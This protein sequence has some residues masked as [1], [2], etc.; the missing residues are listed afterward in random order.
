MSW[1]SSLLE[2]GGTL[3]RIMSQ[4]L[5]ENPTIL[6]A[7]PQNWKPQKPSDLDVGGLGVQSKAAFEA[8]DHIVTSHMNSIGSPCILVEDLSARTSDPCGDQGLPWV[9]L[10]QDTHEEIYWVADSRVW[11]VDTDWILGAAIDRKPITVFS[12]WAAEPPDACDYVAPGLLEDV[13]RRATSLAA[14]A[15]DGESYIV[16]MFEQ[17]REEP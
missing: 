5:G 3:S 4:R 15:F 12:T 17:P 11:P 2:N 8:L 10:R 1:M 14:L 13:G 9:A 6:G 16:L 7:I